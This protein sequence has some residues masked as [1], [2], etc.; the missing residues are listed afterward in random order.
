ME[1]GSSFARWL[2]YIAL[3]FYCDAAYQ[4]LEGICLDRET[5]HYK[6]LVGGVT[7]YGRG[8]GTGRGTCPDQKCPKA[9]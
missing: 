9:L 8:H 1:T 4:G 7:G 5:L 2:F 6:G 3:L